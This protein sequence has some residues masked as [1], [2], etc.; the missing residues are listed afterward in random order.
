[1]RSGDEPSDSRSLSTL[2][3]WARTIVP[4][5]LLSLGLTGCGSTGESVTPNSGLAG[6]ILIQAAQSTVQVGSTDQLT[7]IRQGLSISGGMW[8]V[9]GGTSDGSIT[10]GGL[11]TAPAS[12]PNP[13]TVTVQ[14]LYDTQIYTFSLTVSAASAATGPITIQGAL[15]SLP[16]LSTDLL[17]ASQQNTV[18]TNGQ[19]SVVGGP[20]NGSIDATG[21][22]QAPAAVPGLSTVSIIYTLAGQTA[23]VSISIVPAVAAPTPTSTPIAIREALPNVVVLET[24]QMTAFQHNAVAP[25]G[26][27]SVLGGPSNGSIDSTGLYRAPAFV[28]SSPNVTIEYTLAGQVA[29]A[30]VTV[31]AALSSQPTKPWPITIQGILPT[32]P[33]LGTDQLTASQQGTVSTSGQW[34]VLGDAADG[35]IDPTGL[36]HAPSSIPTPSSI[37]IEYTLAGQTATASLTV[38]SETTLPPAQAPIMIGEA[39]ATVTVLGTDQL[40]ATQQN[41]PVDGGL[42]S[43]IGGAANGYIDPHGLYHAPSLVPA[44]GAVTV[45]YT[46]LGQNATATL[47][48]TSPAEPPILLLEAQSVVPANGIDQLTATQQGVSI[49]SGT[50]V[51]VGGISNG[52]ISSS[53]LY[54]APPTVPIP[55]VVQI[56]YITGQQVFFAT[57]TIVNDALT[58]QQVTPSILTT[59]STAVTVTGTSFTANSEI[60]INSVPIHTEFI[61]GAHLAGTI[62]LPNPLNTTLAV[63]VIDTAQSA[64]ASN[65]IVVTASFASIQVLPA[66]LTGGP[67]VLSISGSAFGVGDVVTLAGT[68]LLT[69]INS[70]SS[71]TASGFLPPWFTGSVM[72]QVAQGDGLQALAAVMVP[73]KQTPVTFDAAARF[74]N[75]AAFGPRP[76]V[77]M[78]IQRLGFDAWISQQFTQPALSF[79]PG[80]SGMTQFLHG[81]AGGNS[82]LRQRLAL[83]LQSFI[84]PHDQDFDPSSTFFEQ[85]LETD[86]SANFRQIL[87]DI[88]S[89]ANLG[90]FLNLANNVASVNTLVQPN[91]NFAREVMQLFSLGPFLL[92]DDGSL[93]TDSNGIPLPTYDQNTVI[94]M[95]RALTGWTYPSPVNQVDVAWGIDWSQPLV[96]SE[97]RH[98]HN[99]KVLFGSVVMPAN[100]TASQDRTMAL[101]AIFNHPNLPPFLAHLLIQRLVT[102]NPTPAYIQ[103]IAAVFEND[104]SGVR[105]NMMAVVHAIL[106][107]PEARLGDTTPSSADGFLK[108]PVLWM[109]ST[110]SVLQ[111]VGSDDQPDYVSGGL[112]ENLWNA[113]TVFGFF[114]PSNNIPGSSINSPEFA[115]MS[116]I[117]TS[118]KSN[119]LW[120][121]ISSSQP[122]FTNDY[123]PGSWLFNN[124]TTV[125]ALL[126]ALNHL[127]YHG[128][129]SP[130]EIST[131][132]TYCSTLNP[133]D[134]QLQLKIAL[135]LAL[136]A[137]SND[138]SQ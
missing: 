90:Y 116:N 50:W 97:S 128:T 110:M 71:I 2:K 101:D 25:G 31:V 55:S 17:S 114:S 88:T 26:Q 92:N 123:T 79:A 74:S 125:P 20:S 106:L 60:A 130:Q 46:L 1:M 53:G 8:S 119:I 105:G 67:I 93:Q 32:V 36:Y 18:L 76:D 21:L 52:T 91:Q 3:S 66:T 133:F 108:E 27:W 11:Y 16:V 131:I 99:A 115:L 104:G 58:L 120:G 24:D 89:S 84:V 34:S 83:A 126:D 70:A 100:Q 57:V 43:V 95:T 41:T 54:H 14:Y 15:P 30:E 13:N 127:L 124:F 4:A 6:P 40:T 112:G 107:D 37:T 118:L 68:P 62:V 113:P 44:A 61:D 102:S 56:G 129:M 81:A 73:I 48:V 98:D 111:T 85:M 82:L 135:F 51:V 59:L 35:T 22:Y 122:G 137:E 29:T 39:Q 96:A 33:T 86:C 117:S 138:V 65:S 103:R 80:S 121:I 63:T 132:E 45:E 38:V 10:S 134:T 72:V 69:K 7:A 64:L 75:Q 94:D 5:F 28:P 109:L 136:D 78:D 9:G 87:T 49:A 77:V 12:I 19:W 42:W 23:T 47:V